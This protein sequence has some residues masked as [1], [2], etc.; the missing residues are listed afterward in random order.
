MSP[1]ERALSA[2]GLAM[3]GGL[4]GGMGNMLRGGANGPAGADDP[5]APW[6]DT[7]PTWDALKEQLAQMQTPEEKNWR[8]V[9]E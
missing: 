6:Q 1:G 9:V 2:R 8:C 7:A 4:F 5:A 3:V